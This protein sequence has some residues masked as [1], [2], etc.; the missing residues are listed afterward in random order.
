MNGY[1]D[2]IFSQEKQTHLQLT[3]RMQMQVMAIP[4]KMP[5]IKASNMLLQSRNLMLWSSGVKAK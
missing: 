3:D 4:T 1:T 2:F 5:A